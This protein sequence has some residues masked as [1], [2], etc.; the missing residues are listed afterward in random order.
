MAQPT[1]AET[2]EDAVSEVDRILAAAAAATA[3]AAAGGGDDSEPEDDTPLVSSLGDAPSGDVGAA[4]KA[5]VSAG[6]AVDAPKE[7]DE[8]EAE[9][10]A[11]VTPPRAPVSKRERKPKRKQRGSKFYKATPKRRRVVVE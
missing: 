6:A 8:A 9:A 3:E 2:S 1:A 5:E 10:E 4:P 7:T 11:E